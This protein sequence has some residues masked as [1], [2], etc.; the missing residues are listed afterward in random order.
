[1]YLLQKMIDLREKAHP[2]HEK[3]FLEHLEDLRKM[4]FRIVITLVVSMAVCFGF[5]DELMALLR[6]PVEQVWVMQLQE[7][8]PH[9]ND[10]A[11]RKIDVET[12]A[13]AK[14]MAAAST[15]LDPLAREA[16]FRS[17]EDENLRF[18]AESVAILRAAMVLPPEKRVWFFDHSGIAPDL[19]KQVEVLLKTGPGTEVDERGNL[20]TMSA[21]K[22]T[23]TFMLSMKLSFF[24]GIVLAFPFL[25]GFVLQFVIPGL[26]AHE[27]KVLWPALGIGFGLF[28]IGV[29]FAYFIVL[30]RALMFFAGW[31]GD[32]GISNDWRIGEYISFATQ[33]TLLFGL[34]F[35]LPVIVMVFVKLGVLGY[36]AMQ[37]TRAY[38]TVGIFLAAAILT[39]TPD[40][41]TMLLMAAPMLIL[42]EI[43]IWLAFFERKKHREQERLAREEAE[44]HA[45][46]D[47]S[48]YDQYDDYHEGYDLEDA[49]KPLNLTN[50][51]F[52][53]GETENPADSA[54]SE[55]IGKSGDGDDGWNPGYHPPERDEDFPDNKAPDQK[56][57]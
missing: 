16:F 6:K 15:S 52:H 41:F 25:L 23:E 38:A 19:R 28:L 47:E 44:R 13:K 43:C 32:L 1:M 24:A 5:Q 7:K 2:D 55:E 8:L 27:R 18:H 10:G 48:Q 4:I 39:P 33:F 54:D 12:W 34:S 22:P 21:L 51:P 49:G 31:S 36:D 50:D 3:P 9:D 45:A 35:E 14:R 40:I 57:P 11:A 26:H 46:Y 53:A 20:L 42:Y 17:F 56:Q 30:P 29:A 37:R